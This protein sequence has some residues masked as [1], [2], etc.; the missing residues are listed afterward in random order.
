[1]RKS[2][3][4]LGAADSR[5]CRGRASGPSSKGEQGSGAS[6]LARLT[7]GVVTLSGAA[8]KIQLLRPGRAPV[9]VVRGRRVTKGGSAMECQPNGRQPAL[10]RAACDDEPGRGHHGHEGDGAPGYRWRR[11]PGRPPLTPRQRRRRRLWRAIRTVVFSVIAFGFVYGA[12]VDMATGQHNPAGS[13]FFAGLFG[14]LALLDLMRLL[15]NKSL[16]STRN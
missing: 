16:L 15:S 14:F 11:L 10:P 2:Y 13:L 4:H 5:C 8:F 9:C 6:A 1:V 7:S 12:Q 3:R